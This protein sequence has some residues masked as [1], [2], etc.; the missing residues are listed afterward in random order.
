[1]KAP[2]IAPKEATEEDLLQFIQDFRKGAENAKAAGFDGV[3]LDGAHGFLI[4]QFL[5]E[6][7]N[8]RTDKWGGSIENRCRLGLKVID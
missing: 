5:R 6:S 2:H 8:K 3:E 1:V 4:D 7:S